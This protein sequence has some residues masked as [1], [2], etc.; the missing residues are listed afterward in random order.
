MLNVVCWNPARVREVINTEAES[1]SDAVV[2][3]VHSDCQLRVAEPIGTSFQHLTP[4]SYRDMSQSD[5]LAA[6]LRPE[7]PHVQL[8]ILCRSGSGKSHL[9]HWLRLHIPE[10]R[11]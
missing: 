9:V 8:A 2:R 5:L 7:R 11:D 4:G 6:F 10:T 3:V 1:V